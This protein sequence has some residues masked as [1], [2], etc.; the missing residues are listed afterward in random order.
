MTST[1][2]LRVRVESASAKLRIGG[3]SEDRGDRKNEEV[4][5]RVWTGVVPAWVQWGEP[6][7]ANENQVNSFPGYLE[8]WRHEENERGREYAVHAVSQGK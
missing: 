1:A 5:A 7:P 8:R 6:V 4:R 3:P 2:I